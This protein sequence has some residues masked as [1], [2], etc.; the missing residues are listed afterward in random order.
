MRILTSNHWESLL[1]VDLHEDKEYG[2]FMLRLE[3]A[4][5][6]MTVFLDPPELERLREAVEKAG[7]KDEPSPE[8]A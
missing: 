8:R 4:D 6:A 7:K 3:G 1:S 5:G 2:R